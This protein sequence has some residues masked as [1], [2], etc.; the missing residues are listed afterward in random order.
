MNKSRL[1]FFLISLVVLLPVITVSLS[2]AATQ[3]RADEDSLSKHLSVFSEV[4]SLVKRAYVEETSVEDLLAGA[5]DGSTDALDPMATYVPAQAV[6]TYREVRQIERRHSGLVVAKERGIAFVISADP[7][8]PAAAA[9]IEHGDIIA[10]VNGVSTRR[11]PLWQF[12]TLL[13]GEPGTELELEILRRG[14]SHEKTLIL[15]LYETLPP[16]LEQ[17][18][19]SAVLRIFRFE[20]GDVA[21]LRQILARLVESDQEKLLIDLRKVAG[22]DPQSA[23]AMAGLFAEGKLGELRTRDEATLQFEGMERPLWNGETVLLVDSGSQGAAEVFATVMRQQAGSQLVGRRTFGHAGRQRMIALS[24][25][26]Q[27]LLTDAFYSGPDGEPINQG[28]VP[29]VTVTEFTRSLAEKDRSIEDLTLERGL[30]VLL[31]DGDGDAVEE[32]VA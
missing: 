26:S 29:D 12:Q 21:T 5:L 2:K 30:E 1:A 11:M 4:L 8:S 9:E 19:D 22:G 31:E 25:G 20:P 13:A 28:L 16:K 7:G 32:D 15:G 18:E 10:R 27:V 24:D 3:Q 6:E 23:Y 17:R 14:Q